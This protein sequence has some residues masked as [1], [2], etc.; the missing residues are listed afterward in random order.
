M[1]HA[2][3]QMVKT[4]RKK[5]PRN[6]VSVMRWRHK[7]DLESQYQQRSIAL[8]PKAGQGNVESL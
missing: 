2:K 8:A 5:K 1:H 7:P 6:K 4:F 3:Q